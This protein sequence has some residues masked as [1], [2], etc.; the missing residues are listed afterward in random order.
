MMLPTKLCC[1]LEVEEAL[2]DGLLVLGLVL[3]CCVLGVCCEGAL[4]AN[5]AGNITMAKTV[6]RIRLVLFI[7]TFSVS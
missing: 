2:D 4:C 3:G 1:A 6:I 7:V 5:A